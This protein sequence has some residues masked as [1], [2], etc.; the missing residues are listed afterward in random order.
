MERVNFIP[1]LLRNALIIFSTGRMFCARN[2]VMVKALG[3]TPEEEI[4]PGIREIT[5]V[6]IYL[7]VMDLT[8][9]TVG[10]LVHKF[11]SW[12]VLH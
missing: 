11:W 3:S 6:V 7:A 8:N 1:I 4:R 10:Y 12:G 2:T 5:K 9:G